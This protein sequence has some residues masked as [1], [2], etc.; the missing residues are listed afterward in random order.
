MLPST[1]DWR[2]MVA[3][4][5]ALQSLLAD[6]DSPLSLGLRQ[7]LERR[8]NDLGYSMRQR[9]QKL[10]GEL[11]LRGTARGTARGTDNKPT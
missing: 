3:Q 1:L 9:G 5:Y 4:R 6:T 11:H 8:I 2:G 10:R 7:T